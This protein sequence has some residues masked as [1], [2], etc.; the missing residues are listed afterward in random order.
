MLYCLCQHTEQ[1]MS[2]ETLLIF[3]ILKKEN[4]DFYTS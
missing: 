4:S 1:R 2:E 3:L